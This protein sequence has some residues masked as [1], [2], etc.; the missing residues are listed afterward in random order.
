MRKGIQVFTRFGQRRYDDA[1]AIVVYEG[2]LLVKSGGATGDL[3]AA[4][5]PNVWKR[6]EPSE[7]GAVI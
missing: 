6:V 1:D 3:V 4:F 2:A 7:T 5:A